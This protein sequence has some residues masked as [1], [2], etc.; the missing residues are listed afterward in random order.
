LTASE[1]QLWSQLRRRGLGAKFRR[2]HAIGP[3][4]VDFYCSRAHLVVEID[5]DVHASLAQTARDAARTAWLEERGYR[6]IRF[7]AREVG[8]NF[9]GVVEAIRATCEARTE[10]Q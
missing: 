5:G 4:I 9:P 3:F 1:E 8:R 7:D 10:G 6:V 2:Q